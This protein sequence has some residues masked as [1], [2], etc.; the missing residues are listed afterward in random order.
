MRK[1][2]VVAALA[3][4]AVAAATGYWV[5]ARRG[6]PH[7][8]LASSGPSEHATGIDQAMGAVLV[9]YDAPDGG[10][11]CETAYI[12]FKLSQDYATEH[13]VKPVVMWLAPRQEFLD[14]CGAL[15]PRR[16]LCLAPRYLLHHRDECDK[17][18]PAPEVAATLVKMR[19]VEGAGI[20]E[21]GP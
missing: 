20:P 1:L 9:Q 7:P 8:R 12:A 2:L 13:Q 4:A 5:F 15:P 16:R 19:A 18:R 17:A 6:P 11:P 10:T 14:R 3:V 21:P